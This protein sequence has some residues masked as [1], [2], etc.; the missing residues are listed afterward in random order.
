MRAAT[1][2]VTMGLLLF[3]AASAFADGEILK[4][5]KPEDG[6]RLDAWEATR[7]SALNEARAGGDK[8][9]LKILEEVLKG[10]ALSVRE[11]F[12]PRGDWRCRTIKVGGLLPLVVYGWFRCRITDDSSGWRLEKLTGSQRL[13]GRFFDESEARMIFVGA[14]HYDYEKPRAYGDNPERYQVAYAFRP[15]KNRL[16]LE[17]P[18]PRHE[19]KLDIL[20]MRR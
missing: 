17:F 13:T 8:A 18:L 1:L 16:R 11:G 5:M 12:D 19:S 4:I 3:M 20:D 15:G 9:E 2:A 7:A 14:G 6:R 10:E